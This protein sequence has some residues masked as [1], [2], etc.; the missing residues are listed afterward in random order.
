MNR[1]VLITGVA[2]GI[3]G[4]TARVFADAG[5][6]V[7]GVDREHRTALPGLNHFVRADLADI[8]ATE[9]P[10]FTLLCVAPQPIPLLNAWQHFI[11]ATD[12]AHRFS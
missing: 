9:R 12:E 3:G 11:E 1:T 10:R 8:Q 6:R 7:I 2:G 4:A 5:W